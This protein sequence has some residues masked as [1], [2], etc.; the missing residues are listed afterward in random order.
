MIIARGNNNNYN[1][2]WTVQ[3]VDARR[4]VR[5]HDFMA[6]LVVCTAGGAVPQLET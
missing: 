6:D 5:H 1:N 3:V 4:V 2:A